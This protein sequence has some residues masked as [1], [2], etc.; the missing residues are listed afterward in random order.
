MISI[1][2]LFLPASCYAATTWYV[3]TDGGDRSQCT[4]RANAAYPG[5][6]KNLNCAFRHPYFLFVPDRSYGE[7]PSWLVAG[8]DTV[9]I[10][11]GSYRMGYKGPQPHDSWQFCPGDPFGCHMPPLPGGTPEHHTRLLGEEYKECRHKPVLL[12]GY[13]VDRVLDLSNSAFVDVQCLEITD[14]S[15]CARIGNFNNCRSNFPLDDYASN[16]IVSSRNTHDVA[17]TDLDIHGLSANGIRGPAGNAITATRVRIAGNSASGWNFDDGS[18]TPSS[19]KISFSYVTV[20]WNGCSEE[21]PFTHRLPYNNCSDDNSAGY[22]DGLGTASVTAAEGWYWKIDHSTFRYNTQD[23][24]DLLHVSDPNSTVEITNSTF[25]GNMGNQVKLGALR[26]ATFR[27]NVVIGNCRYLSLPHPDLPAGYNAHLSDFCRAGGNAFLKQMR[28][29]ENDAIQNNSLAG[30]NG[31]AVYFDQCGNGAAGCSNAAVQF[32]NNLIVG[33]PDYSRQNS[34]YVPALD[35]AGPANY[36][37]QGNGSRRNNLMF[38]TR[39]ANPVS[40]GGQGSQRELCNADPRLIS[41]TDID[42]LDFHLGPGSLARAAGTTISDIQTDIAGTPRR[43]G[44]YDIGAYT[45]AN[46]GSGQSTKP[47]EKATTQ[48]KSITT[49]Q[50]SSGRH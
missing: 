40:C 8:G 27:N 48:K 13:G 6:G 5:T 10:A 41:E 37:G 39:G 20:E 30:M 19:G 23:G 12:G 3:R 18:G 24:L 47:T 50:D 16:G 43:P 14:H 44:A 9:I 49:A 11:N 45:Y 36:F 31:A 29:G 7:K 2:I 34:V 21:Y 15:S 25:Y 32:D 46:A 33:F 35:S 4:G 17:L 22:G 26:T 42:T 28:D 38:H 1:C